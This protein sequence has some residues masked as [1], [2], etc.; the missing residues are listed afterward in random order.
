MNINEA[1]P[2]NYLKAADL[3]GRPF[4]LVIGRAEYEMIGNDRKLILYFQGAKKGMVLNKTNAN[5]IAALYGPDTDHWY[6][7]PVTLVEAMVDYQGKSVPAIR[8]RA[9]SPK[10]QPPR[11][12][13]PLGS[14]AR[15]PDDPISSGP[16]ADHPINDDIPF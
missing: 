15:R 5:N 2:S 4:D 3:Q 1:F 9:P 8:V 10:M 7:Q 11:Q 14:S 16:P 12:A 6:G 13:A